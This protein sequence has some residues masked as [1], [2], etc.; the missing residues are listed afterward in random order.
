MNLNRTT[1][2]LLSII[3][4]AFFAAPPF[5]IAALFQQKGV[6]W[7][8]IPLAIIAVI[9][10][11]SSRIYFAAWYVRDKHRHVAWSLASI[12]GIWGWLIL[13]F[14]KDYSGT[15]GQWDN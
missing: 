3:G 2:S 5:I 1:A 15:V 13:W 10:F 11:L 6:D 14:M 8:M 12:F 4:S 7:P 9:I